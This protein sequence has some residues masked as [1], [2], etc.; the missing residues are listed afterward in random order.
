MPVTCRDL[1]G[2]SAENFIWI[3]VVAKVIKT[4][5]TEYIQ[6]KSIENIQFVVFSNLASAPLPHM[7][8]QFLN[9]PLISSRDTHHLWLAVFYSLNVFWNFLM[10][11]SS[12]HKYS[13]IILPSKFICK[14][15]F[16]HKHP[17]HFS[18]YW[19]KNLSFVLLFFW[20]GGKK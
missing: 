9:V 10:S 2:G 13:E 3:H 11:L 8:T 12:L 5:R 4:R 1:G 14:K 15:C 20:G 18:F 7:H 16:P 17:V 19:Y 6:N